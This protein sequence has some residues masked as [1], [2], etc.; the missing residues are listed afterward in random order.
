MRNVLLMVIAAVAGAVTILFLVR[1]YSGGG[2]QTGSMNAGPVALAGAP[3]QSLPLKRLDG[4]ADSLMNYRGKV[5]FMNLWA[6]WCP[7]CRH[8]MPALERFYTE[9]R[10]RGVMVLG[11]DQ[12]ESARV[13]GTFARKLHI[14]YPILLDETEAYGRAYAAIG[15]PTTIV[16]SRNGRIVKG[17]DGEMTLPQMRA[18]VAPALALK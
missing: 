18:A 11:V 13:A 5:V 15:L 8:E 14:T 9:Y 2:Q 12:G 3:A 1:A 10:S 4:S 6:T 16:I 17:I 7:P